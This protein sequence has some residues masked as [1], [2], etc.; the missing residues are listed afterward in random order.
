MLLAPSQAQLQRNRALKY[1]GPQRRDGGQTVIV[2]P[3]E[4]EW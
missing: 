4:G 2:V 1:E 3:Y